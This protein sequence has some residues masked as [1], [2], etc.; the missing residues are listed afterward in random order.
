[1][2]E[3]AIFVF[4]RDKVRRFYLDRWAGVF[5]FRDLIWGPTQLEDW[6]RQTTELDDWTDDIDAGV[7]VDYDLGKMTWY[8]ENGQLDVPKVARVYESLLERAWPGFEIA[9]ADCG[10]ADL[11]TAAGIED[12][13]EFEFD[14]ETYRPCTVRDAAGLEDSDSQNV[15]H[16]AVGE[17][18]DEQDGEDGDGEDGDGED[19]DRDLLDLECVL[20]WVTVI[21]ETGKVQQRK[22]E[23]LAE[24][25][26]NGDDGVLGQLEQLPP[27]NVPPESVVGEGM[28][29]DVRRK[30]VRLWGARTARQVLTQVQDGW[31]GWDVQW[32][33]TGYE[34]QCQLESASGRLMS[35][36][37][38][39]ARIVPTMLS[40]KR[41]DLSMVFGNLGSQLKKT[42]L[43]ATGCLLI[44]ICIPMFVFGLLAQKLP[45]VLMSVSMVIVLA[46]ALFRFS[47]HRFRKSFSLANSKKDESES[48]P[49]PGPLDAIERRAQLD[50][51]LNGCGMA[52][53]EEIEPH[54]P[55]NNLLNLFG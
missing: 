24:D 29:I 6:A 31:Q 36:V 41:F 32:A 49:V 23:Q 33:D 44:F 47:E 12:R 7:V 39:L 21:D 48:R 14:D 46:V 50:V 54:F 25:L 53:V 20:A 52:S 8:N 34:G 51:L 3:P 45:A 35:E 27:T 16:G 5:L 42:A 55:D 38:A 30:Q 11:A 1:M 4:V 26:L 2:S 10:L 19:D 17:D 40:T 37:D 13:D 28:W 15:G 22:L 18:S 9:F 43:T